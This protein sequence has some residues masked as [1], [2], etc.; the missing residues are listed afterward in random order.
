MAMSDEATLLN[1]V[2]ARPHED[3][4][5]LAYADHLAK[6]GGAANTARAEFIRVQIRIEST[7][8]H[9]RD[10]PALA[11]RERELLAQWGTTWERPLRDRLRPTWSRPGRWLRAQL[12]GSGGSWRFHRGFIEEIDCA[13]DRFLEE[14]SKLF[15]AAP[16]RR[17]VLSNATPALAS[18]IE[19]SRLD[20]L[21]SLHLITDM[22]FDTEMEVLRQSAREMGL[23]TLEL[24]F[25]RIQSDAGDLLAMLRGDEP[26]AESDEPVKLDDFRN[27]A[28]ATPRERDRLREI[29]NHPRLVQRI[30]ETENFSHAEVLRLNDWI[31]LGEQLRSAGAW[32]VVKTFHDLEDEE[33]LCRRLILFKPDQINGSAFETLAESPHAFRE[34]AV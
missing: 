13:A 26:E 16:I 1:A 10:W 14:D 31:Y 3:A 33:G 17:V 11:R 19:D 6:V 5:R 15:G 34:S 7:L 25:P 30:T 8:E 22:E 9:G 27:W 18:L 23:S 21:H 2:L 32:A 20:G 24:R 29:A 12:F 4:P 28:R